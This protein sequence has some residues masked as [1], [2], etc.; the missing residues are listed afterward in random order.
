M[1]KA[2]LRLFL[3][4]SV[5]L[6]FVLLPAAPARAGG[7]C[8]GGPV[9][10][11]IGSTVHNTVDLEGMCFVQTII[12]VQPGQSITWKNGDQ[13]DHMVTGA[14]VTWGS[15]EDLR[16]GKTVSYRFDQAGVYPYACMIHAG[17]VGAVV[18]GNGGA[19]ST[20]GSGGVFPVTSLPSPAGATSA[21]GTAPANPVS[22]GS[23]GP[24]RTIALVTLGLLIAAVVGV[25]SQRVGFRRSQA[26]APVG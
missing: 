20:T 8:H 2:H 1:R 11:V 24:W 9:K 13:M 26:K 6:L 17:M 19:A 22:A 25:F 23:P 5:G 16:P 21:T 7:G 4:M 12:R 15:L 10:D 3:A 18:V 14:G